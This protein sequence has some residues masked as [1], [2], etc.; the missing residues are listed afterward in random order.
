MFTHA[1]RSHTHVKDPVVPCHSSVN[2]GNTKI[3]QLELKV[4]RVF[5]MLKLDTILKKKKEEGKPVQVELHMG[6][7]LYFAMVIKKIKNKN[8]EA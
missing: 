5:R 3:T 8:S 6:E 7:C 2:C 1:K 4:S